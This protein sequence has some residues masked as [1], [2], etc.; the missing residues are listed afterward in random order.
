MSQQF[1]SALAA[2]TGALHNEPSGIA[3]ALTGVAH[4]FG[5]EAVQKT[6]DAITQA[7]ASGVPWSQI[8]AALVPLIL[9]VFTGGKIDMQ[10]IINAILSLIKPTPSA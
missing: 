1:Q 9:S 10:T 4:H 5:N 6:N 8:L 7:R 3:W 2:D